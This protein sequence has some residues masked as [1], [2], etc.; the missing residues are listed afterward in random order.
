MRR[1]RPP[2]KKNDDIAVALFQIVE[3]DLRK[4]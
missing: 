2:V 4:L 3:L 1:V